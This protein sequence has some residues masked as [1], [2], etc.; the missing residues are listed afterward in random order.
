MFQNATK[1]IS[2]LAYECTVNCDT[3]QKYIYT[4]TEKQVYNF[5]FDTSNG[6]EYGCL[7]CGCKVYVKNNECLKSLKKSGEHNHET[8]EEG[9]RQFKALNKMNFMCSD[10]SMCVNGNFRSLRDIYDEVL[11]E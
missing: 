4:T 5:L 11:M 2:K 1:I 6:E 3:G 9:Y 10:W 7:K 8:Q